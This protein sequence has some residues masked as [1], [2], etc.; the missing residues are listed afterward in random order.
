MLSAFL[1]GGTRAVWI[2]WRRPL[3]CQA[4]CES[5][6]E[7]ERVSLDC[8]RGQEKRGGKRGRTAAPLG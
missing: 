8:R 2:D 6:E 3:I 7:E 5:E 4:A 1:L